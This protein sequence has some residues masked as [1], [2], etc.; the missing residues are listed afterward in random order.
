MTVN[1]SMSQDYV[2]LSIIMNQAQT[3]E[4]KNYNKLNERVSEW[5]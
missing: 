3:L 4:M 1:L 2:R 5:A